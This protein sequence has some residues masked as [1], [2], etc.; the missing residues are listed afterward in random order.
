V[1]HQ[2]LDWKTH[3]KA[4]QNPTFE[5]DQH[6]L[7]KIEFD[8]IIQKYKLNTDA[9]S[10]EIADFLTNN[11][12]E[13]NKVSAPEFMEKFGTTEDEAVIFLEWI[14][15]GVKFKEEAIDVAKKSGFQ[16]RL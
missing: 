11:T 5:P 15:V 8:R 7:H 12:A 13:D 16:N 14:K 4:C 10:T 6:T 2:K 1:E 3:K 9:K